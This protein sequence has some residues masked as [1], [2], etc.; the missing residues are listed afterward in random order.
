MKFLVVPPVMLVP[1]HFAEISVAT[2][3]A[4]GLRPALARAE[5]EKGRAGLEICLGRGKRERDMLCGEWREPG[6]Y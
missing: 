6:S 1:F 5:V 3:R 4:R 2:G